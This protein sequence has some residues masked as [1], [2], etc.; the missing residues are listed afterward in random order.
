MKGKLII[1]LIALSAI[2]AVSYILSKGDFI[3]FSSGGGVSPDKASTLKFG[4]Q[5]KGTIKNANSPHWFKVQVPKGKTLYISG[6]EIEDGFLKVD[7]KLLKHQ[8][9]TIIKS[10]DANYQELQFT[11]NTSH[12]EFLLR[13]DVEQDKTHKKYSLFASIV[14][15]PVVRPEN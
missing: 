6:F 5:T 3:S 11:N 9:Q 14:D 13:L 15:E 2:A 10:A 8:Y 7:A 12:N 1:V 4:K